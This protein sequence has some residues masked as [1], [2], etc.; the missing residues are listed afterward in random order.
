MTSDYAESMSAGPLAIGLRALL[1]NARHFNP[2]EAGEIPICSGAYLLLMSLEEP[3]E[4]RFGKVA[5]A[6]L[7][8]GDYVYA[9]NAGGPGG[10]RGR[11]ARHM[12]N[13]KKPHWH[14]DQL[15]TVAETSALA[16]PGETECALVAHLL[17]N[18]N[19]T[20]PLPG[21]GSSDCAV[22]ESHLL[23]FTESG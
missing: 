9:G 3:V 15:T 14:V 6:Q 5:G 10:L 22:C 4:V 11:L 19:F 18:E 16:L 1:P 23:R 21:F 8:A 17:A 2:S 7:A 20:T 13:D 12:R